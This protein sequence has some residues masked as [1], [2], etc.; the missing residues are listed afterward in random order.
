MREWLERGI[1]QVNDLLRNDQDFQGLS[2]RLDTAKRDYD[3]A[4][5]ELPSNQR[6]AIED[7]IALCEELE[8]QKTFTAYYCGKRH[9]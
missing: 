1:H 2:Q 7:Y 8:Y 4:V 9:G 3:A 5:K 6:Q